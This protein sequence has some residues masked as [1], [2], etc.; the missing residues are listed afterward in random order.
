[1][2]SNLHNPISKWIFAGMKFDYSQFSK[3]H[4]WFFLVV[5]PKTPRG[6][7]AV[8]LAGLAGFGGSF[9]QIRAYYE[10]PCFFALRRKVRLFPKFKLFFGKRFERWFIHWARC[11]LVSMQDVQVH[12]KA[13]QLRNYKVRGFCWLNRRFIQKQSKKESSSRALRQFAKNDMPHFLNSKSRGFLARK[14]ENFHIWVK[15]LNFRK[16]KFFWFEKP[17]AALRTKKEPH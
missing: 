17:L 13:A 15:F 10:I 12:S 3:K 5:P 4:V 14:F 1:M 8:C 9:S 16:L 11:G 7:A 6:S 2:D